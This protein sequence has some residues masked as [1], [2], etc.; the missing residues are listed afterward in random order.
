M[1]V[2]TLGHL[3]ALHVTPADIG[4][5]T[6]VKRLAADI[7]DATAN[8]VKLAYVDQGYTEET[9]AHAAANFRQ[10][11]CHTPSAVD[12]R[13]ANPSHAPLDEIGRSEVPDGSDLK[14]AIEAAG[15][16][17]IDISDFKGYEKFCKIVDDMEK[18]AKLIAP[19]MKAVEKFV[20]NPTPEASR[21][22]A[23]FFKKQ[24]EFIDLA[25]G[26]ENKSDIYHDIASGLQKS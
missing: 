25:K 26:N 9:A 1:A 12:Q 20:E 13:C 2:D 11:H 23:I 14:K 7:Q 24:Q 17:G 3:L 16:A 10:R 19:A 21:D 22:V 5:R 6:A 15:K 4:D 18:I 8:S